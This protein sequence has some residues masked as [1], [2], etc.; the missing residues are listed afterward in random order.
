MHNKCVLI[1]FLHRKALDKP[2][3]NHLPRP[4]FQKHDLYKYFQKIRKKIR[5]DNMYCS[6]LK[7]VGYLEW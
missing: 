5:Y 3:N 1:P 2:L 7:L 4:C 6:R